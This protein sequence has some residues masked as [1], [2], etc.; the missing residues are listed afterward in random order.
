MVLSILTTSVWRCWPYFN[1]SPWKDG[2]RSSTEYVSESE[3]RQFRDYRFDWACVPW[4]GNAWIL[5]QES[6]W[7]NH[8]LV[9][10]LDERCHWP[11]MGMDLF[12]LIDHYRFIFR[13]ELSFGCAERVYS[14]PL[15]VAVHLCSL[16]SI[17]N[18]PKNEKKP[19]SEVILSNSENFNWSMNPFV[20]TW[21]GFVK[22]V[23][24]CQRLFDHQFNA[25]LFRN[26]QW[27]YRYGR[28]WG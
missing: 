26:W 17:V 3:S 10:H 9:D 6:F 11:W 24:Y 27:Y 14:S 15:L 25:S 23:K 7:L 13:H 18:F 28:R 16:S 8:F 4:R 22:L 12:C 2:L 20:T 21:P 1:A 5:R 19:N